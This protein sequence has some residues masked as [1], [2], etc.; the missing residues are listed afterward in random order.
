MNGNTVCIIDDDTIYTSIISKLIQNYSSVKET[1]VLGNGEEAIN[2]LKTND[3][4]DIIL[5]DLEMPVMD[6]WEFLEHYMVLKS[7]LPKECKLY[8]CSSSVNPVDINRAKTYD[9]VVDYIS[10]PIPN[11]WLK[12]IVA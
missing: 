9:C 5:L 2:Y 3:A 8:V 4:P 11:E 1:L 7:Q 12:K 6:G 10:K